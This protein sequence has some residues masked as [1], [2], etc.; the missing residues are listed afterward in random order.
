MRLS[1]DAIRCA[2]DPAYR[3]Q[4][5]AKQL[6]RLRIWDDAVVR[7]RTQ[8]GLRQCDVPA[9]SDRQLRRVEQGG[10]VTIPVEEDVKTTHAKFGNFDRSRIQ[11]GQN[12]NTIVDLNSVAATRSKEQSV[13]NSCRGFGKRNRLRRIRF[14]EFKKNAARLNF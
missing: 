9:L 1:L 10:H 6:P 14:A 2:I 7:L 13:S 8:Y 5:A 3:E 12:E 4:R 11:D